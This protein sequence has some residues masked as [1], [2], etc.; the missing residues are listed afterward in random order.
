[1]KLDVIL[2]A[3]AAGISAVSNYKHFLFW[4]ARLKITPEQSYFCELSFHIWG[5]VVPGLSMKFPASAWLEMIYVWAELIPQVEKRA[6]SLII[7]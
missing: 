5:S 2:S 4:I 1:M 7:I 3:N 6:K